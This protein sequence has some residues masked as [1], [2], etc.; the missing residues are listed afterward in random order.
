MEATDRD[1]RVGWMDSS[2]SGK[3]RAE[4]LYESIK[5]Q[6]KLKV[7]LT[8]DLGSCELPDDNPFYQIMNTYA[9]GY[10]GK[11]MYSGNDE[12]DSHFIAS[13]DAQWM[14]FAAGASSAAEIDLTSKNINIHGK[15]EASFT[16]LSGSCSVKG[17]WPANN[18]SEI[19]VPYTV[20]ENGVPVRK[21]ISLG[22]FQAEAEIGLSG[23]AGATA[24]LSAA[25]NVDCSSGRPT[26]RGHTG[27]DDPNSAEL[28]GDVFVGVK[29]G[30]NMTGR[31]KWVASLKNNDDWKELCVIGKKVEIA[32]G[33]SLSGE[34]TIRYHQPTGAFILRCHAG[35]V[36]GVGASGEFALEFNMN[37]I[38]AMFD[39]I[40]LALKKADFHKLEFI[41]GEDFGFYCLYVIFRILDM[42]FSQGIRHAKKGY[43]YVEDV[44]SNFFT[45]S[46]SERKAEELASKIIADIDLGVVESYFMHAPPEVKGVVLNTLVYDDW[47]TFW[48]DDTKQRAAI[49]KI[50][51]SFQ[52]WRD[53]YESVCRM[54]PNG[55]KS[56]YGKN[57]SRLYQF[58]AG[59]NSEDKQAD[60]ERHFQNI[61]I[62]PDG[63]ITYTLIAMDYLEGARVP[64]E[65]PFPMF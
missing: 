6:S 33:L 51:G 37:N 16:L 61:A 14:R 56:D 35:L 21:E 24:V 4:K 23:F 45:E 43:D 41:D 22:H 12:N 7:K 64:P 49:T 15:A 26:L 28:K 63:K 19:I 55:D 10:N 2:L 25:V 9:D 60:M 62:E 8:A 52:S 36:M 3:E 44:I 31:L 17:V 58:W 40:Y 42:P 48:N 18:D 50:F 32:A 11:P 46:D 39:Y 47:W 59:E 65:G 53:Y 54:T 27:K 20:K 30:G 29:A 13:R 38:M 34:F 1:A 5:E 57:A